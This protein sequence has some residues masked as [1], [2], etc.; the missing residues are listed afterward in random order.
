MKASILS[1]KKMRLNSMNARNDTKATS[2]DTKM[3]GRLETV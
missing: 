1:D 2:V 3:V